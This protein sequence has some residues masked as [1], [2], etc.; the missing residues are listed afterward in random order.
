[1]KH[2]NIIQTYC[3]IPFLSLFFTL[4]LAAQEDIKVA[5][6]GNSITE[7]VGG[8]P[9]PFQLD[10]LLGSGWDVQN[11]GVS[12]RTLLRQGDYPYWDEPAFTS[13]LNF[14]PDKVI[15]MLGTNDSKPYN[16]IYNEDFYTDY[17]DL[18]DTLANLD[19][20]PDLWV[21][22]PPKAFSG[23]YDISDSVIFY[24]II[25][26]IDSVVANRDVQLIDFYTLTEDKPEY[27]IDGIHPTAHG[28]NFIAKVLFETLVDSSI[29]KIV[30]T[31]V[32]PGKTVTTDSGDET[33][34][35]LLNDGD[36]NTE[37]ISAGIPVS[38]IIDLGQEEEIDLFQL[39][40]STDAYKGYQYTIEGS[41][42]STDWTMLADQSG[43]S[44]TINL[45]AADTFEPASMQY[46]R[47]TIASFSNSDNDEVKLSEF[48]A[49]LSTGYRHAP[50]M[51]PNM[52]TD[53]KA[54]MYFKPLT[55]GGAISFYGNLSTSEYLPMLDF[56]ANSGSGKNTYFQGSVGQ[57]YAF[58]SELFYDGIQVNSDTSYYTFVETTTSTETIN[59]GDFFN[60]CPNPSN[61][62]FIFSNLHV[63]SDKI[64]LKIYDGYGK[65]IKV[66]NPE[67]ENSNQLRWDCT[68][69]HGN[70][71]SSGVYYCILETSGSILQY[72]AIIF[73]N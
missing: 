58:Y 54:Y 7:G 57:T 44:D 63:V 39:N 28:N 32:L 10:V 24:G 11:F 38:V 56:S 25:P 59:V 41:V 3:L 29:V 30:D 14:L 65:L 22:Y 23:M 73:N 48:K 16:W 31:N 1:M 72:Q 9:F 40:F 33:T 51:Y 2:R 34:L 37:W 42:N 15:I 67:K 26:L 66:L 13:V 19:S 4:I 49:F 64:S 36:L 53:T 62:E 6:I 20:H 69:T 35:D 61:T 71:I 21:C 68:D 5:C 43:R 60:V 18:V 70:K 46:I 8:I 55:S 45:Y 50:L 47:L 52:L 17:I 12:A 27:F